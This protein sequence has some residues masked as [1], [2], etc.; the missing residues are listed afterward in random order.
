MNFDNPEFCLQAADYLL[1]LE[2]D[3]FV[4]DLLLHRL[5]E[6]YSAAGHLVRS[7]LN[8]P[9]LRDFTT[10]HLERPALFGWRSCSPY[11]RELPPDVSERLLSAYRLYRAGGM[12]PRAAWLWTT[13]E[14]VDLH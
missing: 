12:E 10:L 4:P 8:R 1:T 9:P 5:G 2:D 3:Q 13:V 11:D 7:P 14:P 6:Q